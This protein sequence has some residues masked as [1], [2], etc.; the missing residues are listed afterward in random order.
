MHPRLLTYPLHHKRFPVIL[1]PLS[2]HRFSHRFIQRYQYAIYS[3][4]FAFFKTLLWNSL[5]ERALT[6]IG[7]VQR[8]G[9][10]AM[11]FSLMA[12]RKVSGPGSQSFRL[13]M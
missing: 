11:I 13:G 8:G 9:Q 5:K 3:E 1:T 2:R 4:C 12:T 7:A 6:S 10:A